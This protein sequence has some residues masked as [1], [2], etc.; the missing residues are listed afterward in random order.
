MELVRVPAGSLAGRWAH[1]DL[2][3]AVEALIAPAGEWSRPKLQVARDGG[4]LRIIGDVGSVDAFET[5]VALA[6]V[7]SGQRVVT[8]LTIRPRLRVQPSL[9]MA[10]DPLIEFERK[11][12]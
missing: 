1:L 5:V 6:E 3:K 4:A 11:N 9:S 12:P 7:Y 2:P 8:E 10:G